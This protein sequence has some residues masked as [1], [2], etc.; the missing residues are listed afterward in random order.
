SAD[1][2]AICRYL[3]QPAKTACA[4]CLAE[5]EVVGNKGLPLGLSLDTVEGFADS[6]GASGRGSFVPAQSKIH[7][8]AKD[9]AAA[10]ERAATQNWVPAPAVAALKKAFFAFDTAYAESIT[11]LCSDA[12]D[13]TG[14]QQ[15]V[16]RYNQLLSLIAA[17]PHE[18]GR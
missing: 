12:L 17:L 4:E 14:V 8:L 16:D 15:T 10:L 2:D 5:Y 18:D 3:K 1:L 11:R 9:F 7:S 13:N 6:P